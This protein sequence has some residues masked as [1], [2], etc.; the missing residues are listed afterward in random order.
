MG[1]Q[2]RTRVWRNGKLERE[3]FPASEVSDYLEQPDTLVW[4]DLAPPDPEHFKLIAE[5][6]GLD[7]LAVEDALEAQERAKVDRYPDYLFLNAYAVRQGSAESR[8]TTSYISAF[9][10]ERALVTVRERDADFDI[11]DLARRWDAEA[12]LAEHGVAYLPARRRRCRC[13]GP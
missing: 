10:T 2:H 8:L 6:L 9:V 7:A 13:P 11:E 5:E 12:D 4:L 3:D 1:D